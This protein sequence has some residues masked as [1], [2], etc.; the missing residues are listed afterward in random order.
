[1]ANEGNDQINVKINAQSDG[2]EQGSKK[3]ADSI[4]SAADTIKEAMDAVAASSTASS[5]KIQES[6]EQQTAAMQEAAKQAR[7]LA[8]ARSVNAREAAAAEAKAAQ[9]AEKQS[10]W[11]AVARAANA[12]MAA[13]AEIEAA[14]AASEAI[15]QEYEKQAQYAMVAGQS[16]AAATRAG[17][18]RDIQHELSDAGAAVQAGINRGLEM[19]RRAAREAAE[20]EKAASREATAAI[21]ADYTQ[22]A[23][24]AITAGQ[25]RAA[26]AR[27]AAAKAAAGAGEGAANTMNKATK[28]THSLLDAFRDLEGKGTGVRREMLVLLHEISQG[29]WTRFGGS[30]I[31]MGERLD[32]FKLLLSPTGLGITAVVATL[33]AFVFAAGKGAYAANEL[34]RALVVQGNAAGM[35]LARWKEMT[36]AIQ[37][38]TGYSKGSSRDALTEVIGAGTFGP[39][40]IQP[41]AEL[42]TRITNL[43][44]ETA[45]KVVQDFQRMG[46]STYS[47]SR[48]STLALN[49]L[50]VADQ[51]HI[52][53]LEEMGRN[54]DAMAYAADRLNQKLQ[55]NAKQLGYIPGLWQAIK[56]KASEAWDAM[57][58]VGRPETPGEKIARYQQAIAEAQKG[59]KETPFGIGAGVYQDNIKA[60]EKQIELAREEQRLQE[61]NAARSKEIAETNR[62]GK[63][64]DDFMARLR[65]QV[66]GAEIVT[67]KVK[68]LQAKV[69]DLKKA[70]ALDPSVKVPTDAEIAKLEQGIKRMY[71]KQDNVTPEAAYQP[72]KIRAEGQLA[73]LRDSLKEQQALIKEAYRNNEVTVDQ[74]Y[75]KLKANLLEENALEMQVKQQQLADAKAAAGHA[76]NASQRIEAS[77]KVIKVE[78]EIA[79]LKQQQTTAVSKLAAEED[80]VTTQLAKQVALTK[81][82]ASEQ[83]QNVQLQQARDRAQALVQMGVYTQAQLIEVEQDTENKRY[84]IAKAGLQKRLELEGL[85]PVQR[86]QINGQIEQLEAQHAAN[87][88]KYAVDMAQVKMKPFVDVWD[89]AKTSMT[90]FFESLSDRTTTI[91]EKLSKLVDM[92]INQF[93]KIASQM[94]SESLFGGGSGGYNFSGQSGGILGQF[95]GQSGLL[96]MLGDAA[97]MSI[98]GVYGTATQ[99]GLD[100][101]IS[102]LSAV[103]ALATGTPFVKQTGLALIHRG[104]AVVPAA[105]NKGGIFGDGGRNFSVY[106]N[107]TVSGETSR[108]TQQQIAAKAGWAINMAARRNG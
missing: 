54:T 48:A 46:N 96:G 89:A 69:A 60:F 2:A 79:L 25:S 67:K 12:R 65:E 9:E 78:N 33:G 74:Y 40:A 88:E 90:S 47:W 50:T 85:T 91:T 97:G 66:G 3:A 38:N 99:A 14:R 104:E 15:R 70:A 10:R 86:A 56:N 72:D 34:T 95:L 62:K 103:P 101:L 7:W 108:F 37:E 8:V 58:D 24:A 87:M 4:K 51:Q 81:I 52:R 43:T 11:L 45:D 94:L 82:Q 19:R 26:A 29:Q 75:A 6:F 36:N 106:N 30:L 59:M 18:A 28:E 107:F 68:E 27:A 42:V 93:S 73:L 23:N 31:V 105:A 98:G 84:E 76:L 71:G 13:Q 20:A 80:R 44:G 53:A 102:S 35:T 55:D 100:G 49:N 64:A 21:K 1:M 17:A 16:R 83:V 41:V 77:S 22:Q 57:M 5:K 32:A 39:K 92:L 63:D 61:A